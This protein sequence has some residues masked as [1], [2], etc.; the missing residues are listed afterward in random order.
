MQCDPGSLLAR[1]IYHTYPL[2]KLF[3]TYEIP[4]SIL[5][6][7]IDSRVDYYNIAHPSMESVNRMS[8][9]R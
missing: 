3:M 1:I 6:Y 5:S 7:P 9:I 2:F 4:E 8:E